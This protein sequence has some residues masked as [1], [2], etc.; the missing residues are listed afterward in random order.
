MNKVILHTDETRKLKQEEKGTTE[1][2]MVG[3]H[4]RFNEKEF[5]QAPGDG[6]GWGSMVCCSLWG[7]KE[8]DT[9]EWLNNLEGETWLCLSRLVQVHIL[10]FWRSIFGIVSWRIRN[11]NWVDVQRKNILSRRTN[12]NSEVGSQGDLVQCIPLTSWLPREL[13]FLHL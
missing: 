4:H 8:S 12:K 7:R 10:H 3:W 13:E 5:E 1:D 6:E 11:S 9:T 2:K